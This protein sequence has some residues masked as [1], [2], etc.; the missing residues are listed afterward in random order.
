MRVSL[1][2]AATEEGLNASLLSAPTVMEMSLARVR[3]MRTDRRVLGR[4]SCML[5][6]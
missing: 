1:T 4:V 6:I 2:A 3:G 5:V